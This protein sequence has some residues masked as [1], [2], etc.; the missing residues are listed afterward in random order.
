MDKRVI[1]MSAAGG[2]LACGL[3]MFGG[4][5]WWHAR[6]TPAFRFLRDQQPVQHQRYT[7]SRVDTYTLAGEF[8]SICAEI[9]QELSRIGGVEVSPPLISNFYREFWR[10]GFNRIVVRVHRGKFERK[11]ARVIL[12]ADR[13]TWVTVEV[14]RSRSPLWGY[15]WDRLIRRAAPSPASLPP[16]GMTGQP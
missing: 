1:W 11:D 15:L 5:L 8:E 16:T 2:I 3:L 6:S 7:N 9:S 4:A 14:A 13:G 10:P 12:L